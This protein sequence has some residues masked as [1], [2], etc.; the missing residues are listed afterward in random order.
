[1][2][3]GREGLKSS[4]YYQL[5]MGRI[6]DVMEHYGFGSLRQKFNFYASMAVQ[7]LAVTSVAYF[8]LFQGNP[9]DDP[10]YVT[11]GKLAVAVALNIPLAPLELSVGVG[12]AE[13]SR[14]H[15][16]Q[17]ERDKKRK[18]LEQAVQGFSVL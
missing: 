1:L 2:W 17:I 16:N 10:W 5:N 4:V 3:L 11:A 15:L 8:G 18:S 7:P 6:N 9:I 13:S 12:L 14:I